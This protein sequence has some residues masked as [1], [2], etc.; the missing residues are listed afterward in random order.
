MEDGLLPTLL[1]D[2]NLLVTVIAGL[3]GVALLVY[4]FVLGRR[5]RLFCNYLTKKGGFCR[6][7]VNS[8]SVRCAAGH[9]QTWPRL[10]RI[11]GAVGAVVAVVVG[12]WQ[13]F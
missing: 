11:L 4:G 9:W 8:E 13:P 10:A 3:A 6:N 2:L 12:V 1:S 7:P 5:G